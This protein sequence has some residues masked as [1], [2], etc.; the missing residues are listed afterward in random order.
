MLDATPSEPATLER[1]EVLQELLLGSIDVESMEWSDKGTE[2]VLSGPLHDGSQYR[3]RLHLG[4]DGSIAK[5][6]GC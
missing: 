2:V 6:A 3:C 1:S 5:G 4:T